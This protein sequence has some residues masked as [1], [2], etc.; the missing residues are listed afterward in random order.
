MKVNIENEAATKIS[1]WV[2]HLL[3]KQ[4]K[5]FTDGELIKFWLIATTKKVS[6][7]NKLVLD[8]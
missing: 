2:A 1:F 3:A 6:R 7:E 5:P 8:Y 4:E